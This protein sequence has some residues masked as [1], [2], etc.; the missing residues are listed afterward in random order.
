MNKKRQEAENQLGRFFESVLNNEGSSTQTQDDDTESFLSYADVDKMIDKTNAEILALDAGSK[1]TFRK[2]TLN[3]VF[4]LLG[5]QILFMN[6][7]VA[8]FFVSQ[9]IEHPLFVKLSETAIGHFSEL[10]KWYTTAVLAELLGAFFYIVKVVFETPS[11]FSL[12][13]KRRK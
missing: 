9:T 10:T 1:M 2:T 13:T 4:W 3:A 8:W 6:A 11:F 12:R 5:F 7:V